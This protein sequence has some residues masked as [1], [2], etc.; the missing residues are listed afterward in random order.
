MCR[1]EPAVLVEA[2]RDLDC[3][4]LAHRVELGKL[5]D[6]C[7]N[8]HERGVDH[9]HQFSD[10]F[11]R[12][13][14]TLGEVRFR[15][16]PKSFFQTNSRQAETLYS[17]ARD[18]AGLQG[19]ENVY[20][21]YT[22]IGSIALFIAGQCRQVVG[23]EEIGA[24]VEDARINAERN[25]IRNARF[26][27]GDVKQI[28]TPEFA[29]EHGRPDVLITDPPRAGMH[30][31]V[32]RILLELSAPKVVYVSCNPATQARDLNLLQEKYDVLKVRPVDMFPHTHHIENV[33]LLQLRDL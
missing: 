15:I 29:L 13:Q 25:G 21:L 31:E 10:G 14:E 1:Q 8:G 4:V 28:L 6:G 19:N 32:V 30:P 3:D 22:G 20:D 16:G 33:A 17:V 9:G 23:I 5:G 24:A 26:Y 7:A 2:S 27:A 18:F 11:V 12:R